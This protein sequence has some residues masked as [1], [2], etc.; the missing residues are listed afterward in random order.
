MQVI[1]LEKLEKTNFNV[2]RRE[3]GI[4][5]PQE[6]FYQNMYNSKDIGQFKVDVIKKKIKLINPFI[7]I[8][9]Y[10]KKNFQ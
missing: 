6:Q 8:K 9:T 10:K 5:I 4:R 2:V 1:L 7:K 3:R